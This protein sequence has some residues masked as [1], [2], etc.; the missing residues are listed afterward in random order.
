MNR[1]MDWW[2]QSLRDLQHAGHAI[3]DGDHEWAAF[4]SQQSAEK[5]I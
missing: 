4:A 3:E 2:E 5:A 1:W